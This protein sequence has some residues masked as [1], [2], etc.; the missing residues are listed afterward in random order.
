MLPFE[1]ASGSQAT[2]HMTDGLT[3]GLISDLAKVSSLKTTSRTSAFRF[4][5]RQVDPAAVGR[6]LGVEFLV[7]GRV[8]ERSDRPVLKDRAWH[9]ARLVRTAST[10]KIEV[11]VDGEAAPIMTATDRTIQGGRA[12]VG[13]FDDTGAFR[14]I[15]VQGTPA[16]P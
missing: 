12:G 16:A 7:T 8:D 2:E 14:S 6:E 15:H 3:E 11:F 13:S 9:R 10:G 5:G 1:H 4:K